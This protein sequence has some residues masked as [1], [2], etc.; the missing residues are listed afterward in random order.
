MMSTVSEKLLQVAQ[1]N[2]K[3]YHS[4]Q[5]NIV[6]NA[7]CLKGSKSGSAML[8]DDISPVEH[9]MGVRIRTNLFNKETVAL[10]PTASNLVQIDNGFS[11]QKTTGEKTSAYV[12]CNI[13]LKKGTYHIKSTVT[14]SDNVGGGGIALR[15]KEE[16]LYIFN[17]SSYGNSDRTFSIENSKTYPL[18]FYAPYM[19]AANTTVTFTDVQL[20]YGESASPYMPYVDPTTVKVKRCGKN[21]IPYPYSHTTKTQNEVTFTDNG[22]GSI[23]IKGTATA[24]TYFWLCTIDF[25]DKPINAISVDSATNGI[26][27]ASKRLYYNQNSKGSSINIISGTTVEETIYPQIELGTTATDYEPYKECV[28]YTSNTDGVVNG[29]TSLYPNT[30]LMTNTD[31]VLIDCEYYKDID[32]TFNELTTSVALSGGDS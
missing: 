14:K 22:D 28:E 10:S 5:L 24:D 32:K 3:V 8:L 25:G 21:L 26:Y 4:G 15:D 7:E 1:N 18:Y 20:E 27:T 31:G 9:D 17:D 13:Y 12:S 19:S 11:F 6:K 23:T 30:T 2:P 29:V 16:S